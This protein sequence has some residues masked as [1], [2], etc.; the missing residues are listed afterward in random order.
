MKIFQKT[1][2]ESDFKRLIAYNKNGREIYVN[3]NGREQWLVYENDM[4]IRHVTSDGLTRLFEYTPEGRILS[5]KDNSGFEEWW[6]YDENGHKKMFKNSNGKEEYFEY[7]REEQLLYF[8][9]LKDGK[10]ATIFRYDDQGNQIYLKDKLINLEEWW[11][12]N[13]DGKNTYHKDS[14]GL[15]EWFEYDE[16]GRLVTTKTNKDFIETRY[17][18]QADRLIQ[19]KNSSG[20][21]QIYEY[22][23]QGNQIYF[24]SHVIPE[25]KD[26]WEE[27]LI[28][29]GDA[30]ETWKEYNNQNL[31]VYHKDNDGY[32]KWIDYDAYGNEISYKDT[33][34]VEI[35]K[36]YL[37]YEQLT[38]DTKWLFRFEQL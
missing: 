32:E 14:N 30:I 9:Y 23:D 11:E 10:N 16:K 18:D 7:N 26:A 36:Q 13:D 28:P 3:T 25:F 5:I 8:S 24:K 34:G 15:E 2:E 4:L 27:K 35:K 22:D 37:Y 31:M 29:A 33:N 19:V 1:H 12:Y 17:Y 20:Y 38:D 21:E 6:E